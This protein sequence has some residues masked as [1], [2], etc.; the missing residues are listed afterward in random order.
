MDWPSHSQSVECLA[1]DPRAWGQGHRLRSVIAFP[2][3]ET[4]GGVRD[5]VSVTPLRMGS[6]D[7]GTPFTGVTFE[8]E[9]VNVAPVGSAEGVYRLTL[10]SAPPTWAAVLAAAA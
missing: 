4:V 5:Y 10:V 7:M 1:P 6:P 2:V 3:A 8:G 9:V